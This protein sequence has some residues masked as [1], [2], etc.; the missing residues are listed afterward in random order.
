VP[1][2]GL[3]EW[4]TGHGGTS[5]QREEEEKLRA[6]GKRFVVVAWCGARRHA[7]PYPNRRKVRWQGRCDRVA[8]RRRTRG[9]HQ[10]FLTS[11]DLVY[12]KVPN[13]VLTVSRL[14]LMAL[15]FIFDTRLVVHVEAITV[16]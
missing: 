13:K 11:I 15:L 14:E 2:R 5:P 7:K 1:Q 4:R 16:K 12:P 8:L 9:V 3:P 6:S 10:P